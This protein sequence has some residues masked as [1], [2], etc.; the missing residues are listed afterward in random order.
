[1]SFF[2][3]T[4]NNK[5]G[6][7]MIILRSIFILTTIT[8]LLTG[9]GA[10]QVLLKPEDKAGLQ[11]L[12]LI[13]ITEPSIYQMVNKGSGATALGGVGGALIGSEAESLTGRLNTVIKNQKFAVSSELEN[14]LRNELARIGYKV[15]LIKLKRE[16]ETELMESYSHI[17]S[18]KADAIL[19][20]VIEIAGYSTEHYMF[21]PE[22]RPDLKV[23]VGLGKPGKEKPFYTETIMYGYHNF[24]MTATDLD[25]TK[26]HMFNEEE[27]V[28]KAGDK[29]VVSGLKDAV[30]AIAKHVASRL[31]K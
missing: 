17:N 22:W 8:L 10:A 5:K 20:V 13:T 23:A 18:V 24:L 31:E 1:M 16:D 21:S 28:F 27:D 7:N 3:D 4:T 30:K 15:N 29:V 26:K 2:S 25:A 14:E 6:M 19:D 9:C 12:A 11:N